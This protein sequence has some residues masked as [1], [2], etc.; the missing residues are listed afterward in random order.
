M[1][2]LHQAIILDMPSTYDVEPSLVRCLQGRYL[3]SLTT[4]RFALSWHG[5]FYHLSLEVR[6]SHERAKGLI[7][8]DHNGVEWRAQEMCS[9]LSCSGVH[10]PKDSFEELEQGLNWP[11]KEQERMKIYFICPQTIIL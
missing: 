11:C 2:D 3:C 4:C 7:P 1:L 10:S 6:L 8:D 9:D 5:H